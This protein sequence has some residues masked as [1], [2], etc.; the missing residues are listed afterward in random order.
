MS[1]LYTLFHIVCK[2]T[3]IFRDEGEL[4]VKKVFKK[5]IGLFPLAYQSAWADV[6]VAPQSCF[7][8]S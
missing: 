3:K 1:V 8:A 2:H 5:A 4:W 6:S 7:C